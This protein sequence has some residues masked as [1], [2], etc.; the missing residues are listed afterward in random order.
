M[1]FEEPRIKSMVGMLCLSVVGKDLH[2]E[3]A[4]T[5]HMLCDCLLLGPWEEGREIN[6]APAFRELPVWE[7]KLT[8]P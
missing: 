7:C 3:Q 5:E 4:F 8:H 2:T 6:R 1:A